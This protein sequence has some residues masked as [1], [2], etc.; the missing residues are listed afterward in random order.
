MASVS[1]TAGNAYLA[2]RRAH[3]DRRCA[4]QSV[5]YAKNIAAAPAGERRD[6]HLHLARELPRHPHR[7]YSGVHLTD[8]VDVTAAATGTGATSSTP[9]LLT[10]NPY[11]LLVAANLVQ[12][13]TRAPAPGSRSG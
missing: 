8:P 10:T 7:Q 11:D 5:Y 6:G 4:T 13:W 2:G 9:A 1:D 3:G 12:T